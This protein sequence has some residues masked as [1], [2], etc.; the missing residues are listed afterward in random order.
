[1]PQNETKPQAKILPIEFRPSAPVI[2][3]VGSR[4]AAAAAQVALR[5]GAPTPGPAL[6][7]M[8]QQQQQQQGGNSTV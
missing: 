4:D 1:M 7:G 5:N 8:Q 3:P 2:W 6:L